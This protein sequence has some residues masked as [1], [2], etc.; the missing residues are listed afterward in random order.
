MPHMSNW[1]F[2]NK[3]EKNLTRAIFAKFKK[4]K[5][6][7]CISELKLFKI[8][9]Y[10]IVKDSLEAQGKFLRYDIFKHPIDYTFYV[11]KCSKCNN[12]I[13]INDQYF[14]ENPNK[15]KKYEYDDYHQYLIYLDKKNHTDDYRKYIDSLKKQ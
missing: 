10:G 4:H 9:Q 1:T 8:T 2:W 14:F 7:L 3:K 5:C 11:F 15:E 12:I 6:F 13:S